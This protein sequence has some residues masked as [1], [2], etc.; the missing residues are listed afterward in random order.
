MA[1]KSGPVEII[2]D[3][4]DNFSDELKELEAKLDK[5][6]AK[7]IS[8][9]FEIDSEEEIKKV[10]AQLQQLKKQIDSTLDIDVRGEGKAQAIKTA[11]SK[12]MSST[13]H[14]DTDKRRGQF[15]GVPPPLGEG[16]ME[17][18]RD[19]SRSSVRRAAPGDIGGAKFMLSDSDRDPFRFDNMIDM[20][21]PAGQFTRRMQQAA[22]RSKRAAGHPLDD[23]FH[24]PSGVGEFF[25]GG[26]GGRMGPRM[27]TSPMMNAIRAARDMDTG[28]PGDPLT[29]P[30]GLRRNFGREARKR[31][32]KLGRA[33]NKLRPNIMMVWNALAALIPIFITLGAA[34][35]GLAAGMIAIATAGA[36]VLGVGLLGWGDSF[37]ESLQ[38]LQKQAKSL[39]SNLFDIMQPVAR[40]AQPI[41]QDWMEGAGRQV[42]K[43]VGPLQN[44]IR[45]FEDTLGQVGTGIVDWVVR[46]I[47]RMTEMEDTISQ[48]TLRFGA[49]AGDFLI[50]MVTNLIEFAANNQETLIRTA[51]ALRDI[52]SILVDLSIFIT[53][54]LAVLAPLIAVLEYL[55]GFIFNRFTAG[56][57]AALLAIVAM[58]AAL[59][60]MT[61]MTQA[62]GA[63]IL[64]TIAGAI[65]PYI[66]TVYSAIVATWEWIAS[67][68]ALRA[69]LAL[70]GIGLVA[71]GAGAVAAGAVGQMGPERGSA[72]GGR[73]A[74]HGGT[75]INIQG[76]VEKRQMDRLMDE[77]P[78]ASRN[79]RELSNEMNR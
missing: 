31:V 24:I 10:Q 38:N 50:D 79:E 76:D 1:T 25:E 35:I 12:D 74:Q 7:K 5:L 47:N 39:G 65:K 32:K 22:K 55:S 69:A 9:E 13:L 3:I 18:I 59:A 14:I 42:Q 52:L 63:G 71:L 21:T 19:A 61:T 54:I 73:T 58:N 51:G 57:T 72:G 16:P 15:P 29:G 41:L 17:A 48:I 45:A 8:V 60:T 62:A 68:T 30:R 77:V 40:T 28:F 70:T 37:S 67:L 23:V 4:V 78:K 34:A 66:V 49:V 53:R 36:A 26:G 2:V 56:V 43:L 27:G 6:D 64:M 75:T 11:L 20:D 46:V 44:L 33:M